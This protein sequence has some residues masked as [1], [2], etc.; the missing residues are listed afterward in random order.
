MSASMEAALQALGDRAS[1]VDEAVLEYL[2]GTVDSCLEEGQDFDD[3]IDAIAPLLDECLS[4]HDG[5][6]VNQLCRDIIRGTRERLAPPK[7]ASAPVAAAL[8]RSFD[9]P[10]KLNDTLAQQAKS[11]NAGFKEQMGVRV[12]FNASMMSRGTNS[13]IDEESDD[14]MLR[15]L[16]NEKRAAKLDK[17]AAR[18]EKVRSMQNDETLQSLTR[19]PVVL[20][21]QG[22]RKGTSDIRLEDV[23]MQLG[24]LELLSECT[25]TIA[26]G[27]RYGL[28]GRNGIGKTTL[29]KYLSA[30][31][32]EG[33]PPHLQILHIEQEVPGGTASVLECVLATDVE[34]TA[35]LSEER[36]LQAEP[37][38][39]DDDD[40]SDDRTARLQEV[41]ER[42]RVI[43]ADSAPA[44]AAE[45]LSGL[46]F[47]T[48]DQAR[49][50]ASFSGGWRMRVALA[51]ALF[52]CPDVLLLDEP[53]NHLDLHAVM[54]LEEYL[55]GWEKTLIVV[56]HARSFLNAVVTDILHFQN[57]TI[58]R[59][60]GDY[61]SYEETRAEEL[62]Q[63][64]K[65]LEAQEKQR[66]H[67]QAFIDKFRCNAK[68]AS[69]VQSRIKM[70]GRMEVMADVLSDPSL[71]F[72]F[73][74]PEP[75]QPPVIGVTDCS[76]AYAPDK[77]NIFTNV[78]FG[79]DLESRIAVVG[80]N[81][82]GK[83][84]LLKVIFGDLEPTSGEVR[85]SGKVRIGKFSQH[86]VDQLDLSLSALEAFQRAYPQATPADIRKHLG[87]M[88]LG[89]NLAL[90]PMRTLSGGQK[91][92]AAFAQIMWQRPHLLLLDEPTN[93]LDLDAVEALIN[94]LNEFEVR[95][96]RAR[97]PE[98]RAPE[99][100]RASCTSAC[101][102]RRVPHARP[103]RA[104]ASSMRASRAR[105]AA[106]WS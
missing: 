93:H 6:A 68:R 87:S 38:G 7:A 2:C 18:R 3:I 41:W 71:Q 32:F 86:H 95:R 10:L 1:L 56:S 105:R 53:T 79:L 21:W 35:L 106:C 15:R 12:N 26:F 81:G 20:H 25:L 80:P 30:K 50:T 29:L 37:D 61:D 16:K 19:E 57:K 36:E 97:A 73:P 43:E 4:L 11:I 34:R 85:R 13:M 54:W 31:K 48:A 24:A 5:A 75:L 76:F 104:D 62:R 84:T 96:L 67:T 17:R 90:Q 66:A 39:A 51:R 33:I 44:R 49:T 46:G 58:R 47:D 28:I 101:A 55:Q 60:K 83:S 65:K 78:N 69:M 70:L 103:L 92:R 74:S 9:V 77:P 89:G 23:S 91:S 64:G 52:I 99:R 88:G 82:A 94:A 102:S 98:R 100:P 8:D 63:G 22:A 40:D 27:R 59:F 14:M 72:H 42:L 45:I